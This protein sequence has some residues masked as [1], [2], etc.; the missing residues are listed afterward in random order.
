M[1]DGKFSGTEKLSELLK[2]LQRL[3]APV[4]RARKHA[5]EEIIKLIQSE[6][7]KDAKIL[8]LDNLLSALQKHVKFRLGIGNILNELIQKDPEIVVPRLKTF[9]D[10]V[11]QAARAQ[12]IIHLDR[13]INRLAIDLAVPQK[14]VAA[15]AELTGLAELYPKN[16]VETLFKGQLLNNPKIS[17]AVQRIVF[18]A[19]QKQVRSSLQAG[20]KG[21]VAGRVEE[22]LLET[23]VM[24][25]LRIISDKDVTA[26]RVLFDFLKQA[27]RD[28]AIGLRIIRTAEERMPVKTDRKNLVGFLFELNTKE[29]GAKIA[30]I[31]SV[32]AKSGKPAS[33]AKPA[34]SAKPK[35]ELPKKN[36]AFKTSWHDWL[37]GKR[38]L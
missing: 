6:Q 25:A 38:P 1:V 5:E 18:Q 33:T 31:N 12:L 23:V 19:I 10:F 11:P 15:E 37:K 34:S 35:T 22:D 29:A 8:L 17:V 30:E 20:V 13:T 3:D 27:S 7:K 36:S 4:E 28:P 9:L 32:V 14:A 21:R 16:I 24:R 26:R 2:L